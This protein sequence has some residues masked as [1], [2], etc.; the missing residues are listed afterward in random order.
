MSE[1]GPTERSGSLPAAERKVS[2]ETLE[3]FRDFVKDRAN[4]SSASLPTGTKISK[5]LYGIDG[6]TGLVPI[7]CIE[8]TYYEYEDGGPDGQEEDAQFALGAGPEAAEVFAMFIETK[9][10][11]PGGI[12][13][14]VGGQ[15]TLGI[16]ADDDMVNGILSHIEAL[17]AEG[18]ITPKSTQ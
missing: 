14:D 6:F 12:N 11:K 5:G 7:D 8:Y 10:G 13:Y 3:R 18:I 15:N 9:D 4:G 1:T 17:E 2:D 16:E